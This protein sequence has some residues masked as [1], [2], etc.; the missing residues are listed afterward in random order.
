MILIYNLFKTGIT[1]ECISADRR[2]LI[3]SSK[4]IS[5][6]FP[7]THNFSWNSHLSAAVKPKHNFG[8]KQSIKIHI[9]SLNQFIMSRMNLFKHTQMSDTII[10]K[11]GCCLLLLLLL[12][13]HI[14]WIKTNETLSQSLPS[15]NRR[16]LLPL[17]LHRPHTILYPI[18]RSGQTG[19]GGGKIN[20]LSIWMYIFACHM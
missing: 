1:F 12:F 18:W 16:N 5:N 10:N 17:A 8:R 4:R 20:G 13:Y 11:C 15:E 9:K 6:N 14:W 7:A 2:F 3:K 19:G